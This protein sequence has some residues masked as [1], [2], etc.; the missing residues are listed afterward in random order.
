MVQVA[1]SSGSPIVRATWRRFSPLQNR[2]Q[3]F[4]RPCIPASR[5]LLGEKHS[6]DGSFYSSLQSCCD[7]WLDVS[8]PRSAFISPRRPGLVHS[9]C[10]SPCPRRLPAGLGLNIVRHFGDVRVS[11]ARRALQSLQFGAITPPPS[12]AVVGR[13]KAAPGSGLINPHPQS[14]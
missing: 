1:R 6:L 7:A 14:C 5:R 11:M 4:V 8:S 2:C 3:R 12:P 13:Q 10:R 9:P